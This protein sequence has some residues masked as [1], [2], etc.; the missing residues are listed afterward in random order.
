MANEIPNAVALIRDDDFRS[1]I[2]VAAC[3]QAAAVVVNAGSTAASKKLATDVLS[4]PTGAHLN[5]MIAIMATRPEIASVGVTVGEGA[6][7]IGQTLLLAQIAIIWA[8]LAAV[9]YP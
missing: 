7:K 2:Q 8:P 4:N 5:Q 9:M 1:W 3:F 6:G